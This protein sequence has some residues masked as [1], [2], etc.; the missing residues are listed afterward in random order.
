MKKLPYL[1]IVVIFVA[2]FGGLIVKEVTATH[3][4]FLRTPSGSPVS[5]V[6]L[7][8]DNPPVDWG[9]PPTCNFIHPILTEGVFPDS[10]QFVSTG[11]G[12]TS[13]ANVGFW[14]KTDLTTQQAVFSLTGT[15][16]INRVTLFCSSTETGSFLS[17]HDYENALPSF[18]F[19]EK[20]P[21]STSTVS[22]VVNNSVDSLKEVSA[23]VLSAVIGVAVLLGLIFWIYRILMKMAFRRG[24]SSGIRL[25]KKEIDESFREHGL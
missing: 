15:V 14:L 9:A 13:R 25:A 16:D 12:N 4:D 5:S 6:L 1:G 11:F 23:P 21:L 22:L 7:Q 19:I 20:L 2:L 18:T 24:Q 17:S 10:V 3:I 8:W